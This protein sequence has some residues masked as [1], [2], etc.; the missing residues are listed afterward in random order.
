MVE[1]AI[2]LPLFLLVIGGIVDF[3]RA[4]FTQIQLTNAAREGARAAVVS[5]AV[6][7]DIQA[8][9]Q[10]A[11]NPGSV[12]PEL[13]VTLDQT[14]P[15]TNAQV[16]AS[17]AFSWITLGPAMNIIGAGAVLPATL[18]SSAVMKCGG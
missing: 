1:F 17:Y 14:C 2:L 18:S 4:F 11:F 12:P 10:A 16:T 13:T 7:A 9:A 15:G 5:T 6:A 8:R 3:G